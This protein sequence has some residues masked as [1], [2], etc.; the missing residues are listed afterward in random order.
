MAADR[1]VT[2]VPA[3]TVVLLRGER[4]KREVFLTKRPETMSFLGGF[5]VFPGG[6]V[7][8]A[9]LSPEA[10]GRVL[11]LNE[12]EL[13]TIEGDGHEPFGFYTAG[14]RELFEESGVLLLC[15]KDMELISRDIYLEMRGKTEISSEE[16]LTELRDR[17]LFYA[18][19]RLKYLQLF[20]TP[21]LSPQ[22]FY[23]VFFWAVIPEGQWAGVDSI[24]VSDYL[25][26]SPEEAL[27]RNRKGEFKMIPPTAI[28]L[29]AAISL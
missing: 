2:P 29:E 24:E 4:G 22:R 6:R 8:D 9:D 14:I 18:V 12:G 20:I 28:A 26:I 10:K 23:T 1:L 5:Y 27:D 11:G 19:D 25:W 17:G 13:S 21:E 15:D 3:A 7:E 16:F